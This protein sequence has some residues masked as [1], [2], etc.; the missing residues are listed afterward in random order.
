MTRDAIM[1]RKL[2]GSHRFMYTC[3]LEVIDLIM[4]GNVS[5]SPVTPELP[6]AYMYTSGL[7]MRT[8]AF[9]L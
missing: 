7:Q 8:Y 9:G 2:L 5:V 6:A 4:V 3:G 1:S